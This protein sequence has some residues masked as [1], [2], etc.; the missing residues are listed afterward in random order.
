MQYSYEEVLSTIENS[1]RFG[2][3]TGYEVSSHILETLGH[4]ESG[5]P[6]VHIAGTN[7]K[8]STTAFLCKILEQTGKKVGMFT[9]THFMFPLSLIFQF[10]SS[11]ISRSVKYLVT[12]NSFQNISQF[13]MSSVIILSNL[14]NTRSKSPSSIVFRCIHII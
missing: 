2:K 3:H 4:P 9:C 13:R 7:G 6:F 8:G 14:K 10:I 11:L 12:I 1:R 5:L